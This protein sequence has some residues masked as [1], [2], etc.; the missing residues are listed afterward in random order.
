MGSLAVMP[1]SFGN[2]WYIW[3]KIFTRVIILIGIIVKQKQSLLD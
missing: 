1:Q 3:L 2:D